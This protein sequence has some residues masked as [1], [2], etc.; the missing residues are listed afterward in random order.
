MSGRVHVNGRAH[1]NMGRHRDDGGYAHVHVLHAHGGDDH[2]HEL[3]VYVHARDDAQSYN[4][5]VRVSLWISY[6]VPLVSSFHMNVYS[7]VHI[8]L[9]PARRICQYNI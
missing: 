8:Y 3:H 4:Y 6:S 7:Y 9:I 1:K 2:V 5:N